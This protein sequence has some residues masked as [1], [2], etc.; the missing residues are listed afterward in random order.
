MAKGKATKKF[1]KRHLKDVLKHRG[2]ISK[3]KKS[4]QRKEKKRARA[5]RDASP[6]GDDDAE[7]STSNGR[8][9][10]VDDDFFQSGFDL[11]ERVKGKR[12]APA[13][14]SASKAKK[15]KVHHDDSDSDGSESSLE[16]QRT[17]GVVD[18]ANE[19]A[20]DDDTDGEVKHKT[21]LE[22]LKR[23]DPEFYKYLEEN[24]EE[25]LQ[26][27]DD[28]LAGIDLLSDDDAST[29]KLAKKDSERKDR[30]VDAALIERWRAAVVEAHSLRSARELVLAF[31]AA[32][33]ASEESELKFR[34]S[35]P[36]PE[37]MLLRNWI[38][39]LTYSAVYN[40]VIITALKHVP[41]V[42]AHHITSKESASGKMY[43]SPA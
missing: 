29:S 41:D 23:K 30:A 17:G 32:V 20:E 42:I 2:S 38:A 28:D 4:K 7:P 16:E 8:K 12:K 19:S 36:S 39:S 35:I 31:R 43:V 40:K 1:E 13:S 34:Y 5:Q 6:Q 14:S 22:A 26:F 18:A 9:D 25:L 33:H 37:G 24:D 27:E 21:Q 3:I 10:S 15:A 11:P